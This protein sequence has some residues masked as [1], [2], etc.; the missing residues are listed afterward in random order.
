[1]LTAR[2][3]LHSRRLTH[4]P[5]THRVIHSPAA[6]NASASLRHNPLTMY[7]ECH[8]ANNKS[9]KKKTKIIGQMDL[10]VTVTLL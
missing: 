6:T 2:I 9:T 5:E 8:Q 3:Y 10:A 1:M 7:L 4:L